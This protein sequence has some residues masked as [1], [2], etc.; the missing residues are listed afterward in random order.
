MADLQK[1]HELI[2]L[3]DNFLLTR[4][5]D[6]TITF[7]TTVAEWETGDTQDVD[8]PLCEPDGFVDGYPYITINGVKWATMNIGATSET[9]YGLY[10]AW[11]D[12]QGHCL[13]GVSDYTFS[14]T[15]NISI[16]TDLDTDHDAA[17]ANIGGY[18]L[19]PSK[20]DFE[21]LGEGEWTTING[22]NGCK[23]TDP[24]SGKFIFLPAAGYYFY[25]TG[26]NTEKGNECAY[27][28]TDY[29]GAGTSY[30]LE[31]SGERKSSINSLYQA[32]GLPIRARY[33][34]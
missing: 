8:F 28:T 21:E 34:M 25:E 10:F 26:T 2:P 20:S 19:I 5:T 12:T 27:W 3:I 29:A 7:S 15:G 22:V 31:G 33:G 9:Q 17:Q 18:W 6:E 1:L 11:G 13:N 30:F 14:S 24:T 23:F 32:N 16:T 4:G